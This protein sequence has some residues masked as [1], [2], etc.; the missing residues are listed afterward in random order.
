MCEPPRLAGTRGETV[1]C[2]NYRRMYAVPR[3]N[4]PSSRRDDVEF[5]RLHG[6]LAASCAQTT[7]FALET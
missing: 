1:A 6:G 5:E 3:L 2:V 7:G 4:D